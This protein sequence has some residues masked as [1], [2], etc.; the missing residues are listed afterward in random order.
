MKTP[1]PELRVRVEACRRALVELR[2]HTGS[3]VPIREALLAQGFN[4]TTV[5]YV[6]VTDE[7][8]A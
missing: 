6:L 8:T 4:E 7:V 1:Q 3:V 2:W 5:D